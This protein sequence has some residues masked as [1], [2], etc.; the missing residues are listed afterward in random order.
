MGAMLVTVTGAIM[1][2]IIQSLLVIHVVC[3]FASLI[4]F[5]IPMAVKKGASVHRKVGLWYVYTM[6]VVALSALIL[7]IENLLTDR[8][9][10]GLFLGFLSLLTARPLWLAI[11]CLNCK[12]GLTSRY[13]VIHFSTSVVLAISGLGLLMFGLSS[14]NNLATV[15]I[16]FGILGLT[17]IS[18]VITMLRVKY[19]VQSK[20]WLKDHIANMLVGGIAAHT[21]FLVF[22][23]QSML[24]SFQ[25]Q[26]FAI[27]L[28]TAPSVI[29]L[30]AIRWAKH[31]YTSK[32]KT[33]KAI[34]RTNSAA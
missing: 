4:L 32:P 1:E 27:L 22:G 14:S 2:F 11:E 3:G 33:K 24:P 34:A 8:I 25:N 10:L 26:L 30:I 28:W 18:D 6:S 19:S 7:S 9:T 29:G 5:W 20:Q 16:V 12:Q 21:A 23:G 17:A 31:K 15:M 13:K